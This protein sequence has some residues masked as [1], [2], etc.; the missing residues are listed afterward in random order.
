[1]SSARAPRPGPESEDPGG[2]VPAR[3][4]RR[5]V[6][7]DHAHAA[8]VVV[9]RV[10]R[11]DLEASGLERSD[12]LQA[13]PRLDVDERSGGMQPWTAD[14]VLRL[15]PLVEDPADDQEQRAPQS[16]AAGGAPREH[17]PVP[18]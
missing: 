11:A 8:E 14:G 5:T 10:P 2:P 16:R 18:V 6:P 3:I 9:S 15:D 1:M 7:R 13:Q 12:R 17:D 4:A